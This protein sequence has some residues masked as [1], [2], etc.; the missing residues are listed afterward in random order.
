M[1]FIW[2]IF[3]FF[4]DGF[5]W[6]FLFELLVAFEYKLLTQSNRYMY[7]PISFGLF[8]SDCHQAHLCFLPWPNWHGP[9]PCSSPSSQQRLGLGQDP[10]LRRRRQLRP[11]PCH[12]PA[13]RRPIPVIC[14]IFPVSVPDSRRP[15]CQS[16]PSQPPDSCRTRWATD[17]VPLASPV[18]PYCCMHA[19]DCVPL[20]FACLLDTDD[21]QCYLLMMRTS[22]RCLWWCTDHWCPYFFWLWWLLMVLLLLLIIPLL[23]MFMFFGTSAHVLLSQMNCSPNNYVVFLL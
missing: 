11:P 15:R 21:A 3:F 6:A 13:R 22:A 23:F 1:M 16:P 14:G 19:I 17:C 4:W 9:T 20:P 10:I 2:A 12:G 18:R 5:I 8:T 7:I